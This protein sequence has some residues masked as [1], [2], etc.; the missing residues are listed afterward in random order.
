VVR[1]G[2]LDDV[3]NVDGSQRGESAPRVIVAHRDRHPRVCE[4]GESIIELAPR[5]VQISRV[6]VLGTGKG[7]DYPRLNRPVGDAGLAVS[8]PTNRLY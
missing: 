4:V 3:G 7:L 1:L 6:N 8:F 5:D 2:Q